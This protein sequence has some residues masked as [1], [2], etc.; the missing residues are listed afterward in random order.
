MCLFL[1]SKKSIYNESATPTHPQTQK[2]TPDPASFPG[3]AQN[4]TVSWNWERPVAYLLSNCPS[5]HLFLLSYRL[6]WSWNV[7]L[8]MDFFSLENEQYVLGKTLIGKKKSSRLK[9]Q[10]LKHKTL[11][12]IGLNRGTFY[13]HVSLSQ[14]EFSNEK[15]KALA[16]W[17]RYRMKQ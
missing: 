10:N 12:G 11:E 1:V 4:F 3:L 7:F 5:L 14:P 15:K 13:R 17:G 2:H 16:L 8:R 9:N 6:R